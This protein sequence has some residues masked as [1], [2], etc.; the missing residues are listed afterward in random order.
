[1]LP[2][3]ESYIDFFQELASKPE[4]Y[5]YDR[6]TAQSN[7]DIV[8]ECR[9]KSDLVAQHTKSR[10]TT[11]F[12][13]IVNKKTAIGHYISQIIPYGCFLHESLPYPYIKRRYF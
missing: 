13:V 5:K 2:L 4:Y 12:C 7:D 1:M 6:D 10:Y 3:N 9:Y 8:D 11:T